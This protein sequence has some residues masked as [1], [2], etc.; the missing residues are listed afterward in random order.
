MALP[1]VP[2]EEDRK[3]IRAALAELR[4]TQA[5]DGGEFSGLGDRL[6]L[7]DVQMELGF[8]ETAT[9][10]LVVAYSVP[11]G[12]IPR[13]DLPRFDFSLYRVEFTGEPNQDGSLTWLADTND[14]YGNLKPIKLGREQLVPWLVKRLIQCREDFRKYYRRG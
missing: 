8:R 2:Q 14:G 4:D 3:Y 10:T 11:S 7:T 6:I 12:R 9:P 13:P 1:V 5:S